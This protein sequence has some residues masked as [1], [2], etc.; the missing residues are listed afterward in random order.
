MFATATAATTTGYSAGSA[1]GGIGAG[2]F[3][4]VIGLLLATNFRGFRDHFVGSAE[5]QVTFLRRLPPW[6]SISEERRQAQRLQQRVLARVIGCVFAIAGPVLIVA[7][8][9]QVIRHSRRIP[10]LDWHPHPTWV[11]LLIGS[12]GLIGCVVSLWP[13]DGRHDPMLDA[14]RQ[15]GLAR[16]AAIVL[17][18]A[19]ALTAVSFAI[20]IQPLFFLGFV[21]GIPATI[22]MILSRH[23]TDAAAARRQQ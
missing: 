22:V 3:A 7:S 18:A 8:A 6:R 16:G 11:G 4:T 10:R 12:A 9:V 23:G 17:A 15:G 2:V 21:I 19:A 1:W 5:S 14:W 13:R 20:Q